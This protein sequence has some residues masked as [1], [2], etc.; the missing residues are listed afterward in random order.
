MAKIKLDYIIIMALA[1][2]IQ[3][4]KG[5]ATTYLVTRAISEVQA[6]V[7]QVWSE[8][9]DPGR[10]AIL[11]RSEAGLE[12]E[13][14]SKFQHV[15]DQV[16][17]LDNTVGISKVWSVLTSVYRQ[18]S[19]LLE[20]DIVQLQKLTGRVGLVY[21]HF[22]HY[23][24]NRDEVNELVIKDFV[25]SQENITKSGLREI[26]DITVPENRS[27]SILYK[28]YL[29]LWFQVQLPY[30]NFDVVVNVYF[31][32]WETTLQPRTISCSSDLQPLQRDRPHRNQGLRHDTVRL[33][34]VENVRI[35]QFHSG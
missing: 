20:K 18:N 21:Q 8:I 4:S 6:V 35:W 9:N 22:G 5:E 34:D 32:G 13:V 24:V 1:A 25:K 17:S 28:L 26:H 30:Q 23:L 3:P 19:S 12:A 2:F 10:A 16:Y 31:P 14:L 29:V 27:Q 33:H 15:H 11:E 7:D